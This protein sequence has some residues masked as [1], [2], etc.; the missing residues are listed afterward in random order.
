LFFI[1]RNNELFTPIALQESIRLF[2]DVPQL[3]KSQEL[4]DGNRLTYGNVVNGYDPIETETELEVIYQEGTEAKMV[5]IPIIAHARVGGCDSVTGC[6]SITSILSYWPF[7]WGGCDCKNGR[8]TATYTIQ[9]NFPNAPNIDIPDGANVKIQIKDFVGSYWQ[10]RKDATWCSDKHVNTVFGVSVDVP[11]FIWGAASSIFTIADLKSHLQNVAVVTFKSYSHDNDGIGLRLYPG[12]NTS[13]TNCMPNNPGFTDAQP[14]TNTYTGSDDFWETQTGN[15]SALI[16]TFSIYSNTWLS[17]SCD[18]N[19]ARVMWAGSETNLNSNGNY[20]DDPGWSMLPFTAWLTNMEC[21]TAVSSNYGIKFDSFAGGNDNPLVTVS[22]PTNKE[23][24]SV[25]TYIVSSLNEYRGYK[26]GAEHGFGIVYYD[27]ANRSTSVNECGEIYTPLQPERG[28]TFPPTQTPDLFHNPSSIKFT[29][30][31]APPDWASHYQIVYTGSKNLIDFVHLNVDFFRDESFK[32]RYTTELK[33]SGAT[34]EGTGTDPAV[35]AAGYQSIIKPAASRTVIKMDMEALIHRTSDT[36]NHKIAWSWAKGDR[37]RFIHRPTGMKLNDYE[38][39]GIE[40]DVSGNALFYILGKEAVSDFNNIG[41]TAGV[42]SNQRGQDVFVEIYRPEKETNNNMYYE[43]GH[44][45]PIIVDSNQNRVH[46]VNSNFTEHSMFDDGQGPLTSIYYD[47]SGI[48]ITIPHQNQII[49][50]GAQPAI[51][52]LKWGD[53]HWRLRP[54]QTALGDYKIEDF[55]YSDYFK[56]LGWGEGRPNVFLPDYKKTR[57]DSTIF[58]S[59]PYIA[60]T[61]INGLSTFYPDVSFQEYDKRFNSIQKLHSINDA[62]IIF[63]E[64]KVSRAMVSRDVLFDASGE[65]NVAISKNVL[66]PA[67]PYIGEYGICKNPESFATFGFRSYF[68]DIRRGAVMRLSQDGLTPISE[69]RMKNFFTDYCEE[70]MDNRKQGKFNCYGVYDDKF[71]EYV[72]SAPYINWSVN[73]DGNIQKFLISGFTVGFNEN[74][75]KWNSFYS[76][77]PDWL[78]SYN[79]GIVSWK[80]GAPYQHNSSSSG[81]NTFYN[82][83]YMSR[84]DFPSNISPDATKVY[85]NIAEESTDIWEVEINTRNGQN[86]TVTTQEFTNGQSF[87]WEEGHGTKENI[88]HAVIKGDLNSSGGKVEGDRIR[89]TSIMTSLTLPVGPSQEENTLFSIKFGITPSGSPDLLGN[90]Q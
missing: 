52:Y 76:Y 62:L 27:K 36:D 64:D 35:S 24:N 30:N 47:S 8:V 84:L 80:D 78:E 58:Y 31:H 3:A 41:Y 12:V 74:S 22:N 66:S 56:S 23:N 25:Y 14:F 38:I 79:T 11:A 16:F 72:I 5:Q 6:D 33:E 61:K 90:V 32:S 81:Y 88:H 71:D 1:F 69:A 46:S 20:W 7:S 59:E 40:E 53:I 21:G 4:I 17:T 2:D 83:S 39:V 85:N 87:V 57:R 63:Q 10:E 26:S 67:V 28:F 73:N 65:Q 70:V 13:G 9:W 68:F 29:I 86:T 44:V 37:V 48:P 60:N 49:G 89:D 51:A 55:S 45:N 82:T 50:T 54:T 19:H 42:T 18:T 43:F 15:D 75:K 77:M 34:V